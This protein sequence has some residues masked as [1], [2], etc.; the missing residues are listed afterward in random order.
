[1]EVT[2]IKNE[3]VIGETVSCTVKGNDDKSLKK[4]SF[5]I[6][7]SSVIKEWNVNDKSASYTSSFS[8]DN[9]K[10]GTYDYYSSAEDS[11][12]NTNE[13]RGSFVLKEA[14]GC[15]QT[16]SGSYRNKK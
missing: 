8:T 11:E 7:D 6:K 16:Y 12:G 9:W 4:M 13:Y 5:G 14:S 3:Y 10:K 2:G 15:N 1:M